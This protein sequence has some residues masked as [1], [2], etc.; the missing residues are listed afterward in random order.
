MSG[1]VFVTISL[2]SLLKGV[3]VAVVEQDDVHTI[4]LFCLHAIFTCQPAVHI[5]FE[6]D[7]ITDPTTHIEP[8]MEQINILAQ[9]NLLDRCFV[10]ECVVDL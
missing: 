9:D 10:E 5:G 4:P 2:G 3:Q 6:F 1:C 7:D 8:I